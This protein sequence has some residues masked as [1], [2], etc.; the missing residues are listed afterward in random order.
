M[1]EPWTWWCPRLRAARSRPGWRSAAAWSKRAVPE[2][3]RLDVGVTGPAVVVASGL[4]V[5][6]A[7]GE[8][9]AVAAARLVVAAAGAVTGDVARAPPRLQAPSCKISMARMN[10]IVLRRRRNAVF[11]R[12]RVAP[13]D[14][15]SPGPL[16]RPTDAPQLVTPGITRCNARRSTT[17]CVT[18]TR[19]GH[20]SEREPG[21]VPARSRNGCRSSGGDPLDVAAGSRPPRS[22]PRGLAAALLARRSQGASP[23][24]RSGYRASPASFTTLVVNRDNDGRQRTAH[25]PSHLIIHRFAG[26]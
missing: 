1:A 14:L 8:A 18:R 10:A 26:S 19:A 12:R 13:C 2:D 17:T 6:G 20:G 5:G 24:G 3:A 25:L 7:A 23:L 15:S 9:V 21:P 16:P 4:A 22:C 11:A